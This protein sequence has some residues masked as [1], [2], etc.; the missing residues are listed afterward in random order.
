MKKIQ[1]DSLLIWKGK[2]K[3]KPFP[4]LPSL[5]RRPNPIVTPQ[6]AII[7]SFNA[8]A[9]FAFE[10]RTGKFAWQK[11]LPTYGG[12]SLSVSS[13]GVFASTNFGVI[14]LKPKTGEQVWSYFP[15]GKRG[16][17]FYTDA[18]CGEQ[19][20]FCADVRGYLHALDA[21]SG[22]LLWKVLLSNNE[23]HGV[24]ATVTV[25]KGMIFAISTGGELSCVD[26]KSGKILWSTRLKQ[27]SIRP[28]IVTASKIYIQGD[29]VV[30]ILSIKGSLHE[31]VTLPEIV[32]IQIKG[33]Q[34]Y[35]IV[36]ELI[37]NQEKFKL[38]LHRSAH[39]TQEIAFL[40]N[41]PFGFIPFDSRTV[42]CIAGAQGLMFFNI[43]KNESQLEI[44]DFFSAVPS[45]QS[46]KIYMLGMNYEIQCITNPLS[47]VK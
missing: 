36:K 46:S 38:L 10:K 2:R 7:S 30:S 6:L 28:P 17:W 43:K 3:S 32:D 29:D 20:V 34:L 11:K 8:R 45:V 33:A 13:T 22:K 39:A 9:V 23:K 27:G 31:T 1:A 47:A 19:K 37:S 12:H 14:R 5:S 16:E 40:E 42:L 18:I 15:Y 35:I 4:G 44:V 21:R 25:F 24:N 26:C 41:D